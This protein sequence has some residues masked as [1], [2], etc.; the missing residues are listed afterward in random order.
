MQCWRGGLYWPLDPRSEE[1]FIE[2][3]AHHLGNLCRFT[4]AC[5]PFYSVAEHSVH[6]S[7]IVPRPLALLGLLHDAPEAYINDLNRPTK[8]DPQMRAYRRIEARN[9][10]VI[11]MK[12]GLPEKQPEEIHVAD[13]AMLHVEKLALMKALPD[14]MTEAWMMGDLQPPAPVTIMGWTPFQAKHEFLMRFRELT[15]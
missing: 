7:H 13:A 15:K 4:G 12:F 14:E 1:V 11:A 3:I 5:E 6:V 10:R 9:W 2:D 8:H